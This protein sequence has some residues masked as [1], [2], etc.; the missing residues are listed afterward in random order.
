MTKG[1]FALNTRSEFKMHIECVHTWIRF[2]AMQIECALNQSTSGGGLEPNS[3]FIHKIW[4]EV[5]W[6]LF[7]F[8]HNCLY[9]SHLLLLLMLLL[10]HTLAS[11]LQ[12]AWLLVGQIKKQRPWFLHG[13]RQMYKNNWIM[14]SAIRTSTRSLP[15]NW[16]NKSYTSHRSSTRTC[17]G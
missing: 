17:E 2:G 13:V 4:A 10:L 3:L 14:W 16:P 12:T 7:H 8:E 9:C 6:C 5:M 11:S 15:L 1:P